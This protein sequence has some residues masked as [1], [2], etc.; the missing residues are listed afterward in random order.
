MIGWSGVG[1]R[2]KKGETRIEEGS[3]DRMISELMI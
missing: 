2:V 1:T 3:Q